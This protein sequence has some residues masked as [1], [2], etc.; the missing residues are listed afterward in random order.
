[1]IRVNVSNEEALALFPC[2]EIEGSK[3]DVQ[4]N[5]RFQDKLN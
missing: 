2:K 3:G 1:M 5:R 4:S